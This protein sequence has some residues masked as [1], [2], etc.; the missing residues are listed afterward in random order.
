MSFDITKVVRD[1]N[2]LELRFQSAVQYAKLQSKAHTSYPVPPACPPKEQKGECHVNFIRK[3]QCSF[4]W[5]WGPSFPSQGIWKDVRIEAYNIS[6]LNYLT[7]LPVYDN[8]SQEWTVE[9]EASFDVVSS[10]PVGGQVTVAI[11]QLQTLQTYNIKLQQRQKTVKLLVKISKAVAGTR[12]RA[13]RPAQRQ[14]HEQ[15]E[16]HADR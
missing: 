3:E 8:T 9:I 16:M 6:H 13:A 12:H 10:K 15:V 4:S 14:Q 1:T 2:S 11:P 5:D 7:F